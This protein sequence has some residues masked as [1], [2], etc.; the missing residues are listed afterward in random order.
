M[1][2]LNTDADGTPIFECFLCVAPRFINNKVSIGGSNVAASFDLSR[3]GAISLN[4]FRNGNESLVK[5]GLASNAID[6]GGASAYFSI[7]GNNIYEVGEC[8]LLTEWA[9]H[10]TISGNHFSG[11]GN[12]CVNTHEDNVRFITITGNDFEGRPRTTNLT[13]FDATAIRIGGGVSLADSDI[14]ITSNVVSHY[15]PSGIAVVPS[16]ADTGAVPTPPAPTL[17]GAGAV[18]PRFA[19]TTCVNAIGQT[20]WG[21]ESNLTVGGVGILTVTGPT[22]TQ[23][24]GPTQG[25]GWN[26]FV[27]ATPGT[28]TR[29]NLQVLA[30]GAGGAATTWMEP[31]SGLITGEG[32]PAADSTAYFPRNNVVSSNVLKYPDFVTNRNAGIFVG[33]FGSSE[34]IY[35]STVIGNTVWDVQPYDPV[36]KAAI[37]SQGINVQYASGGTIGHNGIFNTR[38]PGT[39]N[40]ICLALFDVSGFSVTGNSETGCFINVS[41]TSD[42]TPVSNSNTMTGN[43]ARNFAAGGSN[44]SFGGAPANVTNYH[45][46]NNLGEAGAALG[47]GSTQNLFPVAFANLPSAPDGSQ[48]Y[49]TNCNATC[50]VGGSSGRTCFRENGAWT[51]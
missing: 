51:H 33:G 23:C 31:G 18:T 5:A 40:S 27:S 30:F 26:V 34:L 6:L 19:R 37:D 46:T 3:D 16:A 50:T 14:T 12:T 25:V 7:T 15:G 45:S 13:S 36:T 49:C 2:N 11:Y 48:I 22:Q 38:G 21:G 8:V 1:E 32:S 10:S 24:G 44:F 35:N 47:T 39:A 41:F 9:H 43:I 29:Q 20:V 28:E 42:G 17:G 4:E